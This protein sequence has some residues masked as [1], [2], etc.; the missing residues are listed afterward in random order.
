MEIIWTK[1]AKERLE[2]CERSERVLLGCSGAGSGASRGRRWNRWWKSPTKWFLGAETLW[3]RNPDEARDFCGFRTLKK[4]RSGSS[5]RY[6]GRAKRTNTGGPIHE[7][8]L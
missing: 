4:V 7:S 2:R 6:T 8:H 3:S 1:H 5:S